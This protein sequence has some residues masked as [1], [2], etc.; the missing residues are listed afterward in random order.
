MRHEVPKGSEI[1][2]SGWLPSLSSE[3][4][5]APKVHERWVS[6]L[7]CVKETIF[8]VFDVQKVHSDRNV[9]KA[10]GLLGVSSLAETP[11]SHRR[12]LVVAALIAGPQLCLPVAGTHSPARSAWDAT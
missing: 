11:G 9:K 10:H 3:E 6:C 4:L 2:S 1:T 7:K 12:S 8:L 5:H